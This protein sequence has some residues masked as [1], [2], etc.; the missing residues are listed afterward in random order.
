MRYIMFSKHLQELSVVE[1]G[2]AISGLGLNGV[3]LTVRPGGHIVPEGVEQ[4]LPEAVAAL[5]GVGVSVPAIVVEIHHRR[6]A[7]AIEVCRAAASVGAT[8]LRT[9]SLRY[10]QFGRM[11]EEIAAARAQ[12]SELEALGREFGLRLCVHVHSGPMLSAQA[13]VLLD[14][15]GHT[16]PRYVGVS[17]DIAHLTVEGGRDGWRQAIDLLQGRV[18]IVAVKSFGWFSAPDEATGG[19]RWSSKIVPLAQGTA[20]WREAFQLLRQVG[21]DHDGQAL[22]SLHSEYQGPDTWRDLS[23]AEVIEQTAS[24]LAW[25]RRQAEA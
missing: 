5:A 12:A 22:V 4:R 17:L 24:D 10:Q 8:H 6:E 20:R 15:I 23:V 2:R 1:A 25:L 7:G 19:T 21:W 13:G 9:S 3:E 16:D 14:I 18:G 11:R